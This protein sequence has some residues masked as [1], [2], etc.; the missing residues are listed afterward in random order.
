MPDYWDELRKDVRDHLEAEGPAGLLALGD[1]CVEA[2]RSGAHLRE[3]AEKA[4]FSELK[5]G[6]ILCRAL[7]IVPPYPS[8]GGCGCGRLA[9]R[10]S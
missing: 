10:T 1:E 5:S 6:R 8:D 9:P 7:F 2:M 3:M 4:P